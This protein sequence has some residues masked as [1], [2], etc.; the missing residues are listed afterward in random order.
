MSC[1]NYFVW[2]VSIADELDKVEG[3]S[4]EYH[5]AFLTL[6]IVLDEWID[7]NIV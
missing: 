6:S 2:D 5:V 7:I 3:V 4:M 1:P